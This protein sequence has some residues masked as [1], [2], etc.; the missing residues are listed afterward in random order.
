MEF[1]AAVASPTC[2]VPGRLPGILIKGFCGS[3]R[4]PTLNELGLGSKLTKAEIKFQGDGHRKGNG[5]P[6]SQQGYLPGPP[7]P[8]T[9]WWAA[10][11]SG[12]S[13]ID[14]GPPTRA[15]RA[16]SSRTMAM[17]CSL[18]SGFWS[19]TSRQ[20]PAQLSLSLRPP[21]A[22]L[23]PS[24]LGTIWSKMSLRAEK[25]TRLWGILGETQPRTILSYHC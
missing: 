9:G 19:E 10:Q 15:Q 3:M 6:F 23:V 1:Q 2:S 8:G 12:L 20:V 16:P 13:W 17:L 22:R 24:F 4:W 25:R 14:G 18:L 11:V 7:G 5:L 21:G